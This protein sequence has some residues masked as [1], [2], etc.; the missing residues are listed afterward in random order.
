MRNVA[1]PATRPVIEPPAIREANPDKNGNAATHAPEVKL[2][3]P[4]SWSG[5]RE[6][7]ED[8]ASPNWEERLGPIGIAV[9]AIIMCVLAWLLTWKLF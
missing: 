3:R 9:S 8:K 5:G 1:A 6:F 4:Q 7:L 2:K